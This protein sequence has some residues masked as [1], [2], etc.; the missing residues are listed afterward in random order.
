MMEG[1]SVRG[2]WLKNIDT[3]DFSP[4][5]GVVQWLKELILHRFYSFPNGTLD[6]LNCAVMKSITLRIFRA[7]RIMM[8]VPRFT[9]LR[10]PRTSKV[11]TVVRN[12]FFGNTIS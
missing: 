4:T 7:A 9:E 10:V 11:W 1:N 3:G 12:Y 5:N 8:D 6:C 2:D